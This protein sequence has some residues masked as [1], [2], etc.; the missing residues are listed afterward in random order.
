MRVWIN[1]V[2]FKNK[3][4]GY[5]LLTFLL[6]LMLELLM[7]AYVYLKIQQAWRLYHSAWQMVQLNHQVRLASLEIE[8]AQHAYEN[9][10]FLGMSTVAENDFSMEKQGVCHWEK[11][12]VHIL[13]FVERLG[14]N[15]CAHVLYHPKQIAVY[16]Q[17]HYIA[18]S[19]RLRQARIQ[20]KTLVVQAGA[21]SRVCERTLKMVHAGRVWWHDSSVG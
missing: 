2:K 17:F 13:F 9:C 12:D 3:I 19:D 4:F 11:G 18:W 6:F 15:E 20:A 14:T 7:S 10:Y 5:L 8:Q 21:P 16:E 1:R